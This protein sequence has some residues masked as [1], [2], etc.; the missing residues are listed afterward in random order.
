MQGSRP[1]IPRPGELVRLRLV[2]DDLVW[3]AATEPRGEEPRIGVAQITSTYET[4]T[5]PVEVQPILVAQGP[6]VGELLT[7]ASVTEGPDPDPLPRMCVQPDRPWAPVETP[8][9]LL[10]WNIR[11]LSFM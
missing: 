8:A 10:G 5:R 6:I 11:W 9:K 4:M 3:F 1:W 2:I 7:I